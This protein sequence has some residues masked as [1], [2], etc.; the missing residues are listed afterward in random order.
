MAEPT[1]RD[2]AV[3]RLVIGQLAR[4]FRLRTGMREHV[5][6]VDHEHVQIVFL[7]LLDVLDEL[8]GGL[9]VVYFRVREGVVPAETVNLRLYERPFVQVLALLLVFVYPQFGE[10][11]GYLVGHKTA[12][13]RVAGILRSRRSEEH[14]SEL[15]SR[16]YLVC[17]L[18]LEKKKTTIHHIIYISDA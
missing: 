1:Q 7:Q 13:Y 4:H 11:F 14:T 12:E 8:L 5:D 17:R 15:Q 10:D 9:R 18:L 3:G 2:T 16:Q 6:E